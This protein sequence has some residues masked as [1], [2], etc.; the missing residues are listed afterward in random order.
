LLDQ[1]QVEHGVIEQALQRIVHPAPHQMHHKGRHDPG[2]EQEGAEKVTAA[3][4]LVEDQG[5]RHAEH[6]LAHNGHYGEHASIV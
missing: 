5:H 6:E 4:V 3:D 2:Q 1:S